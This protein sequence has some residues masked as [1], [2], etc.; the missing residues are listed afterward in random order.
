M[1]G[2]LS[3]LIARSF[4]DAPVIQPRVPSLFETAGDEFFGEL[5][6]QLSI[7][8]WKIDNFFQPILLW[9]MNDK[10][11]EAWPSFRFENFRDRNW[12]ECVGCE[13]VN[14]FS[15]KRDDFA[16]AQQF[17]RRLAVG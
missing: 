11:I 13:S 4:N 16:L 9:K 12:I 10:R 17:N 6:N 15:R 3:N 7:L 14:R 1:S 2:F 5:Q 8:R